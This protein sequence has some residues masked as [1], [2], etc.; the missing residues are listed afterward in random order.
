VNFSN[1]KDESLLYFYESIR[2]QVDTTGTLAA[3]I[4]SLATTPGNM[5][6]NFVRNWTGAGGDLRQ[7]IGIPSSY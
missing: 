3:G 7:S 2:R 1:A 6:T 4:A 5:P